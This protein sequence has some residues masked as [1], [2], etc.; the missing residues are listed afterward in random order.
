MPVFACTQRCTQFSF[1]I[2]T[3]KQFYP[4]NSRLWQKHTHYAQILINKTLSQK[5]TPYTPKYPF[6]N[7]NQ[8]LMSAKNRVHAALVNYSGAH[9]IRTSALTEV[10]GTPRCFSVEEAPRCDLAIFNS[11]DSL[12]LRNV[13]RRDR[14]IANCSPVGDKYS[15]CRL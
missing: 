5:N 2:P 4:G 15:G 11:G 1:R 13:S 14:N 12:S 7:R 8:D 10:C 6:V 3:K 9:L